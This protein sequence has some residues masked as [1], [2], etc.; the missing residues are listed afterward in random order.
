M[1]G[2][3]RCGLRIARKRECASPLAVAACI[4]ADRLELSPPLPCPPF[5]MGAWACGRPGQIGELMRARSAGAVGEFGDGGVD[6]VVPGL[7]GAVPEDVGGVVDPV[8]GDPANA[9]GRRRCCA[10]L[11]GG[12]GGLEPSESVVVETRHVSVAGGRDRGNRGG[13]HKGDRGTV[14]P[15]PLRKP[16]ASEHSDQR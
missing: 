15:V 4:P 1:D 6:P 8:R 13:T 3:L 11:R 10:P 9:G 2:D 5:R 12:E 16:Y 7:F 14:S